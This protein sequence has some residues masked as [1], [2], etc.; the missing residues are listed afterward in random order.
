MTDQQR[1]AR[2]VKRFA[3]VNPDNEIVADSIS[4][5]YDGPIWKVFPNFSEFENALANGWRI[6]PVTITE[7]WSDE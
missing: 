4:R 5:E 6:A 3:A 1:E 2:P 7:G